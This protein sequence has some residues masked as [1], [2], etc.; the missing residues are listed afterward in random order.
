VKIPIVLKRPLIALD[1][2]THDK[3]DPEQARIIELGFTVIYPLEHCTACRGTGVNVALLEIHQLCDACGGLGE[4]RR[5]SKRWESFIRPD[6]LISPGATEVHGITNDIV[7]GCSICGRPEGEL[8]DIPET[9]EWTEPVEIAPGR[10]RA[11]LT[12]PMNHVF[13]PWPTFKELAESFAKGFNNCDYAG[14]NVRFDVRCI[15]GEMKR[16]GVEWS[17][18]DAKLLDSL[19]LW[20]L[21]EP[22]TLTHAVRKFLGREP[23]AA[24]RALGDATDALEVAFAQLELWPDLPRDLGKLHDLCYDASAIDPDGKFKWVNG[25]VTFTFGKYKGVPLKQAIAMDAR[26]IKQ[27]MLEKG[28]FS[29]EVKRL[30]VNALNGV[31]PVMPVVTEDTNV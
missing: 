27:F 25:E 31:Y 1:C 5:E 22:R 9:P 14:Y 12:L 28:D 3:C 29:V 6:M 19:R 2:E 11:E 21:G 13:T 10:M 23:S 30:L 17:Q 7:M 18:G 15:S 20:Q 16:A 26:Y 24:H 8:H 4:V